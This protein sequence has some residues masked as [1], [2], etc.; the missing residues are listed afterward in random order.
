MFYYDILYDLV[1]YDHG[2][3]VFGLWDMSGSLRAV[4]LVFGP[5]TP[6]YHFP[7]VRNPTT[8][9]NYPIK[10]ND[11][12]INASKRHSKENNHP[13]FASSP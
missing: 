13:K 4:T 12:L 1:R 6:R 7:T 5:K 11:V 2:E 9:T 8:V 3:D 10:T